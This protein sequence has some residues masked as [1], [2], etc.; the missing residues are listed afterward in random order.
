MKL[1]IT[2]EKM[3]VILKDNKYFWEVKK[4]FLKTKQHSRQSD[5][6]CIQKLLVI[7]RKLPQKH[8]SES[9]WYLLL[10]SCHP[11]FFSRFFTF[12]P[13]FQSTCA[14]FAAESDKHGI[15]DL[16]RAPFS[17]HN[18]LGGCRPY[19]IS[20][21]SHLRALTSHY[22]FLSQYRY[23]LAFYKDQHGT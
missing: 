21:I 20:E 3:R 6:V 10:E 11:E 5:L 13:W 14:V 16:D 9:V 12:R 23:D 17:N 19:W 1:W 18:G 15:F 4:L 22:T 7:G 8:T 2:G